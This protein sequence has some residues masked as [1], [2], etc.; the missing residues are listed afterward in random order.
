MKI[1]V[2]LAVLA[3]SV[4]PAFGAAVKLN[5]IQV[6][7]DAGSNCAPVNLNQTFTDKIWA[8]T[9]TT[10]NYSS[11]T[12]LNSTAYLNPTQTEANSLIDSYFG[13]GRALFAYDVWFVNSF[14][15]VPGLRGLGALGGDGVVISSSSAAVD[16]L[17]HELGHNFGQDH[18][19]ASMLDAS[20]YLM[21]SGSIRSIPTGTGD[22]AP[23]GL[24]LDRLNAIVPEVTVDMIGATPFESSDFFDVKYLSGAATDLGLS[25]LT[26]NL[27]PANAFFDITNAD[28]GRSGS[29]FAYGRLSGVTARDIAISGLTDGSSLLRMD[30][31]TDSFTAGDALSFGLDMDLFSNIDGFGATADELRASEVTLTFENGYSVAGDLSTLILSSQF[32]PNRN[33]DIITSRRGDPIAA[34]VVP[35]PSTTSLLGLGLAMLGGFRLLFARS[36]T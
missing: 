27:A 16:T 25:S 9:G 32:D 3:T 11:I 12:Q 22:V 18:T 19:A 31:A 14:S 17:A 4:S 21:A 34:N 33:L 7:D 23:D 35:S 26:I 10:F 20:R 29:P 8:Q 30:F 24:Q 15:G 13:T 5:I 2:A 36:I 28:P 6:C 1:F